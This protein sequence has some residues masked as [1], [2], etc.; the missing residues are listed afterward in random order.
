MMA[1]SMFKKE[2]TEKTGEYTI[3]LA[4]MKVIVTIVPPSK[5]HTLTQK[6]QASI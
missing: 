4:C 2:F 5:G 1:S 3:A 6:L